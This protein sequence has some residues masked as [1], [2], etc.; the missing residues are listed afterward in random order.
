MICI[1]E[2][3]AQEIDEKGIR[4]CNREAMEEII[5]TLSSYFSS[6][7]VKIDGADNFTFSHIDAEYVFAQKKSRKKSYEKNALHQSEDCVK[8]NIS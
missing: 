6:F 5:C 4:E 2:K 8:K 3:T 1:V 7:F